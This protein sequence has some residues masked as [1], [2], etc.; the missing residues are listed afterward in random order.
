[1]LQLTF[2]CGILHPAFVLAIT[3]EPSATVTA[4]YYVAVAPGR[5]RAQGLEPQAFPFCRAPTGVSLAEM[6]SRNPIAF[7]AFCQHASV[8]RWKV[9]YSTVFRTVSGR[10]RRLS[11]ALCWLQRRRH[12]CLASCCQSALASRQRV[13]GARLFED[14]GRRGSLARERFSRLLH[15]RQSLAIAISAALLSAQTLYRRDLTEHRAVVKLKKMKIS[16]FG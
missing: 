10:S 16:P 5:A 7:F 12:C 4:F 2:A 11:Q 15:E 13:H 3:A 9:T 14:S 8:H 1:M 6:S